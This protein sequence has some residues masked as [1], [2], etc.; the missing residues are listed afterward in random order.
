MSELNHKAFK[1]HEKTSFSLKGDQTLELH[2]DEVAE[3]PHTPEGFESFSL[4]FAGKGGFLEQATYTLEHPEMKQ[5]DLFL[6]PISQ[7]GDT[8]YYESVFNLK[9]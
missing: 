8:V 4:I 2:L 7:S 6:V 5:I 1:K 9:A 3:A